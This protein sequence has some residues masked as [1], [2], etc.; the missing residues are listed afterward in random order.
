LKN[1]RRSYG[2]EYLSSH[3][4]ESRSDL[5]FRETD[6][7]SASPSR[8]EKIRQAKIMKKSLLMQ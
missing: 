8:S 4:G 7:Q 3:L 2:G 6:E 1:E 5:K